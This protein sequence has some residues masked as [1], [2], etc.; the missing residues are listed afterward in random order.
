MALSTVS[1]T[2]TNESTPLSLILNLNFFC[3]EQHTAF[4]SAWVKPV[5]SDRRVDIDERGPNTLEAPPE[6]NDVHA[7]T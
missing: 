6:I 2:L 4:S 7:A 1:V 3:R 5:S